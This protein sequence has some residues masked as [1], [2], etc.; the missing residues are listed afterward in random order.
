MLFADP[1]KKILPP[2]AIRDLNN[3]NFHM[4]SPCS[5]QSSFQVLQMLLN[6]LPSF[7]Q[8]LVPFCFAPAIAQKT[9]EGTVSLNLPFA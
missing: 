6:C 8:C 9:S 7:Y 1:S 4:G 3:W 5:V 2:L